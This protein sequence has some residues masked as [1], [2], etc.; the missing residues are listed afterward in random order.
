MTPNRSEMS[1]I[2]RKE[3]DPKVKERLLLILKIKGDGVIPATA[4]KELH[5]SR[6]W[7]SEWLERYDNDGI[8]DSKINPILAD[9]LNF[10]KKLLLG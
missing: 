10:L 4:A 3:S 8:M 7:S 5:R 2:Y 6:T 9:N 1:Q